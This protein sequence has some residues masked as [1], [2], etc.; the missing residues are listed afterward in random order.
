MQLF[1][2]VLITL[3][4]IILLVALW[5]TY[6]LNQKNT[7]L[8]FDL[9]ASQSRLTIIEKQLSL[10]N[11]KSTADELFIRG[12]YDSALVI[13]N[14]I[15]DSL[16]DNYFMEARFATINRY[17]NLRTAL[18][19][20]Q[21]TGTYKM[22]QLERTMENEMER[23]AGTFENQ[24]DSIKDFYKS[25]IKEINLKLAETR[26]KLQEVP[27]IDRLTFFNRNG[28]RI[29]YF[30]E[31][32]NGKA[33]GNGVGHFS[34]FSFYDGEWKNNMRHGKG[35]YLWVDGHK[36]VGEYVNDKREGE[37]TYFWITGDRYEGNWKDDKRNGYGIMYDGDNQVKFKGDW[38]DGE[39]VKAA[40]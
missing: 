21:S 10:L 11:Q 17:K 24:L 35:T 16:E 36:Y 23:R 20:T 32:S 9:H 40:N 29:I 14:S 12:N 2:K 3:F 30:G 1:K 39:L 4:A 33:D 28:T 25:E 15:A 18:D 8:E 27:K 22:A 37:G 6:H 34:T 31:V 5:A 19:S 7:E 13:Y 38:K 26:N